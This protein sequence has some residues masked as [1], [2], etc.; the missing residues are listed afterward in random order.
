MNKASSEFNKQLELD[1]LLNGLTEVSEIYVNKFDWKK[2]DEIVIPEGVTDIGACAFYECKRLKKIT[3]PD[4]V[5]SI[6][7]WAFKLCSKLKSVIIPD[8][9]TS[10]GH[11]AFEDCPSFVIFKGKTIEEVRSMECYPW[12]FYPEKIGVQVS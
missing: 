5:T 7:L 10:I 4:S 3:I 8:S 1:V 12:N 2:F 9:V 11:A 6:G